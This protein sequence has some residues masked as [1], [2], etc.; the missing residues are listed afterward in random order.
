[1]LSG[2]RTTLNL[3]DDVLETAKMLAARQRRPLGEAI[4]GLIRSAVGASSGNSVAKCML[5]RVGRRF[6]YVSKRQAS[7][8]TRRASHGCGKTARRDRGS[9]A[10]EEMT[11]PSVL[12]SLFSPVQF[13]SVLRI[14]GPGCACSVPGPEQTGAADL[15]PRPRRIRWQWLARPY[16]WVASTRTNNLPNIGVLLSV[17]VTVSTLPSVVNDS[18][19][20]PASGT[21]DTRFDEVNTV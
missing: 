11:N 13:I 8:T 19:T 12:S 3:A 16:G 2:M 10:S 15:H 5:G 6:P 9:G 7:L 14:S 18:G 17:N 1:M 4:S 20:D 21:Q